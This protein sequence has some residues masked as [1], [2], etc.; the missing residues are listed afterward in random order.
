MVSGAL[1]VACSPASGSTVPLG[2][3]TVPCGATD[4][5]GN[6]ASCPSRGP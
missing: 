3:T 1:P 6:A 5:A 4:A 2:S